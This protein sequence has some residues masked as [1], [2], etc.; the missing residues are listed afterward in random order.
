M[1]VSTMFGVI[2]MIGMSSGAAGQTSYED[3]PINYYT[4]PLSD[5][6][7][8]LQQQIDSGE[9]RLDYDADHGYLPSVLKALGVSPESQMLVFSKTSFQRERISPSRPRAVYFNDDVYVGWVQNGPV[10]EIS[11]VDPR[12]GAIFYTLAQRATERPQFIRDHGDCL[13]CHASSRTSDVPGH[14]VRSVY[15]APD[16]QPRF[17]AGT[18]LTDHTSPLS[19]RW[20]GWYVTGKHGSQ[21]HMGNVVAA[22]EEHPENLDREA[23]ANVTSLDAFVDTSP[24]LTCDSDLVALMVLEHQ[25]EMHNL[26]TRAGYDTRRALRDGRIMN[27][28]LEEP[29]DHISQSTRR[30]IENAGERLLKYL[31]FVGETALTEPICGTSSFADQFTARGPRDQRGRSLRDFDLQKRLFRY[32]CSYLIYSDAFTS[33]PAP[34]HDYLARR[35]WEILTGRDA[36]ETYSH[37]STDD[38]RAILEILQDTQHDLAEDWKSS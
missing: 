10:M 5:P 16:G 27:R 13:S 14:L 30:R 17:E 22:D 7:V 12:Q 1:L 19:Q 18:F 26:I 38:R 21:R 11:S 35:L 28:L 37:L 2:A 29:E 36:S 6:V 24:Y 25:T 3:E 31:L 20:G 33:L 32:P 8:R 23:G 4:T 9:I 15:T 34:L